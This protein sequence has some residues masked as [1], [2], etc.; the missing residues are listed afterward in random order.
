MIKPQIL[1]VMMILAILSGCVDNK[2]DAYNRVQ[3]QQTFEVARVIDG[4]TIEM[5]D[6]EKVR[7]ICINTPEIGEFYYDEAK[8]YLTA[9]LLNKNVTLE[10]DVTEEDSYGRLLRYVYLDDTLINS[11]L[12]KNG[13]AEVIRYPPDTKYCDEFEALE[14]MAIE[15]G[16]GIWQQEN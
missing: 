5:G 3:N 13:Y 7:F 9:K 15:K 8:E 6:G 2:Q 14:D 10:K 1:L 12:V 4:D 11:E 16:I